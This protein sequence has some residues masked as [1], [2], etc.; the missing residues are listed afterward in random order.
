MPVNCACA[1][2]VVAPSIATDAIVAIAVLP[3]AARQIEGRR[4]RDPSR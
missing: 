2:S 4:A 1:G 3:F